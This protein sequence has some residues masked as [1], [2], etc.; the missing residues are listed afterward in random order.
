MTP[1]QVTEQIQAAL[2]AKVTRHLQGCASCRAFQQRLDRQA[3]EGLLWLQ[4][5]KIMLAYIY[6]AHGHGLMAATHW[7]P[8]HSA[9]CLR[10]LE[11]T[12]FPRETLRDLAHLLLEEEVA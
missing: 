9:V 7:S 5:W 8:A 3:M 10:H 12:G 2:Q 1:E 11:V 4:R 6:A